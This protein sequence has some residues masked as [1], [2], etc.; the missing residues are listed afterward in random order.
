VKGIDVTEQPPTPTP[1]D[2]AVRAALTATS[3][4]D[5]LQTALTAGTYP[6]PAYVVPLIERCGI[7]PDF[8]VRDML[9]WALTRHPSDLT[10]PVLLEQLTS[11]I[12]QARS[13]ALHT[14]TKVGDPQTWSAIST[15]MLHDPDIGVA[16]A[17]W[18]AAVILSPD[19]QKPA[20]AIEL[21]KELGRGDRST[22]LSL[23]RALLDLGNTVPSALRA[24]A[25]KGTP[26]VKLHAA[27]TQT[28]WDAAEND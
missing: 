11:V 20:L 19:H 24:A 6:D 27:D 22:M 23:S 12:P 5:R 25:S 14:L 21:V 2:A 26:A 17:A 3:S 15:D 13:Q 8:F 16:R 1:K 10:V 28:M 7:E 4:S 9:T 18:R